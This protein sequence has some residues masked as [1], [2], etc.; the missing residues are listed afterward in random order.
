[1]DKNNGKDSITAAS[2][3]I[4]PDIEDFAV[5]LLTVTPARPHLTSFAVR[6]SIGPA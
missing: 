1:M 2:G 5:V 4:L 3:V 6:C